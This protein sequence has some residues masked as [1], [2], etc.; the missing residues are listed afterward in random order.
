MTTNKWI[1][2]TL[3]NLGF[4]LKHAMQQYNCNK[5]SIEQINTNLNL[6]YN[7]KNL[8]GEPPVHRNNKDRRGWMI[9]HYILT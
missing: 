8:F 1:Q 5:L 3:R 9:I 6:K 7:K 4:I 2:N